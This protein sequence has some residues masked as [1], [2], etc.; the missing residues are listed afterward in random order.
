MSGCTAPMRA[1]TCRSRSRPSGTQ[2]VTAGS[3]SS[4]GRCAYPDPLAAWR[5]AVDQARLANLSADLFAAGRACAVAGESRPDLAA[6]RLAGMCAEQRRRRACGAWSCAARRGRVHWD[7]NDVDVSAARDLQTNCISGSRSMG[8][9]PIPT[10]GRTAWTPAP[11]CR[12]RNRRW[13][14]ARVC[15]WKLK[16]G[17]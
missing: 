9:A 5:R 12:T 15:G 13:A 17:N 10:S 16:T 11:T 8:F 4:R 3:A 14:T 7:F 2:V 1:P 6:G